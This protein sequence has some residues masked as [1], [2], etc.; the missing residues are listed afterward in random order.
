MLNKIKFVSM[1]LSA[2]KSFL[3]HSK[4]FLFDFKV[5]AGFSVNLV[6]L[7]QVLEKE[8][9]SCFLEQENFERLKVLDELFRC[10]LFASGKGTFY[11]CLHSSLEV[12]L[13]LFS[14]RE[15]VLKSLKRKP[16]TRCGS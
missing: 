12:Q 5:P 14:F 2:D 1:R 9:F 16:K 15:R 10:E 3:R 7:K 11:G 4:Q 8:G 13:F 6:V